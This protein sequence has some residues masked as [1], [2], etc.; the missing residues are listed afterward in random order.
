MSI[1]VSNQIRIQQHEGYWCTVEDTH[2][3][4]GCPGCTISAWG[5]SALE[6]RICMNE[7]EALALADAICKL[8]R[9]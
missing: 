4:M 6:H 2:V 9:S 5:N 8:F 1:T 3:D 7:E